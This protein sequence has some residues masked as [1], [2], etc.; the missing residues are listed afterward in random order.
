MQKSPQQAYES[1]CFCLLRGFYVAEGA[2][3]TS[4][5]SYF[6]SSIAAGDL[7]SGL[8][9]ASGTR[10]A[11]TEAERRDKCASQSFIGSASPAGRMEVFCKINGTVDKVCPAVLKTTVCHS[12]PVLSRRK[13][14]SSDTP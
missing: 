12:I 3:G 9:C 13:R 11:T 8:L 7:K 5:A 4:P 1:I 10:L 14:S 6:E 2:G